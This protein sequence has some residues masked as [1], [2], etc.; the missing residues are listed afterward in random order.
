[1]NQSKVDLIKSKL[2]ISSEENFVRTTITP[3]VAEFILKECN[4]TNRVIRNSNLTQL[5]RCLDADEWKFVS[6]AISFDTD[7]VLTNG[8]HRL[9]ACT[10]AN[11]PIEVLVAFGVERSSA[12]DTGAK[13]S[14]TDNLG[15]CDDCDER[16]KYD[17]DLHRIFLTAY[18]YRRGHQS[19]VTLTPDG[20]TELLNKYADD[21]ITCK[22][23]GLF[24][25]LHSKGCNPTIVKS[26]LFLAYLNGVDLDILLN[27]VSV[28]RT[29][30]ANSKE[31]SPI[32]GLR[33]KLFKLIGGGRE[34]N[35]LRLAYT[36][37]CI[38]KCNKGLVTKSLKADKPY[39]F[40]TF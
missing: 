28:L 13:R 8:Q 32:I 39:Y 16:I 4:T 29:G 34:T 36:Q 19:Q 21:L 18:Q 26:S 11:K 31:D 38:Y 7:G 1:M 22:E 20:L 9:T 30:V 35:Q 24:V 27:I 2:G 14:F 17:R 6:D 25:N 15:I 3:E 5:K 37:H 10:L 23:S 33:D 40:F 12:I